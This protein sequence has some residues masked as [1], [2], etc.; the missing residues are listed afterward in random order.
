[1]SLLPSIPFRICCIYIQYSV[2]L[3][4]FP[5]G[6]SAHTSH[7][8]ILSIHTH[9]PPIYICR[10]FTATCS[11]VCPFNYICL[12]VCLSARRF[13][14]T[15]VCPPACLS[16]YTFSSW[17]LSF[18]RI[19]FSFLSYISYYLSMAKWRTQCWLRAMVGST[20]SASVISFYWSVDIRR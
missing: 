11:S 7:Q 16:L 18:Q 8:S 6:S 1:M 14:R 4:T 9:Q 19:I 13:V 2:L 12:S 10:T 15:S 20:Y 5:T 17:N 3:T